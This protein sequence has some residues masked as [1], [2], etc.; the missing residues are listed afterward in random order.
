MSIPSFVDYLAAFFFLFFA[1][2]RKLTLPRTTP[3]TRYYSFL[4]FNAVSRAFFS[5]SLPRLLLLLYSLTTGRP[6]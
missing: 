1:I 6:A 3:P 2:P 4:S 5:L